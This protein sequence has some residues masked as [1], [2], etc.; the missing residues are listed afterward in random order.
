MGFDDSK[1]GAFKRVIQRVEYIR[2]RS[3]ARR[4][5]A[6]SPQ[7]LLIKGG[8]GRIVYMSRRPTPA[9]KKRRNR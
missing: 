1:V 6:I 5:L 3:N 7:A 2:L 8:F 9:T 4:Y